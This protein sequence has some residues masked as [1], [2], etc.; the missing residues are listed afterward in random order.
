MPAF[1]SKNPRVFKFKPATPFV[2]KLTM[3]RGSGGDDQGIENQEELD[4]IS[5]ERHYVAPYVEH[6]RIECG[7]AQG[8]LYLPKKGEY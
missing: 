5:V 4:S 2:Y 7:G 6:D 3:Y 8:I 1:A